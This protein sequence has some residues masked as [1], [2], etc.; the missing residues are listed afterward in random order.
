M[1]R[2]VGQGGGNGAVQ[3]V[4]PAQDGGTADDGGSEDIESELY[5]STR[6]AGVGVVSFGPV[7]DV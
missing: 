4:A 1:D 7:A 2:S 3:G 5:C 6:E